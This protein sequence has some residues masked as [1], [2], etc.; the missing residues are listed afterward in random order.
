MEVIRIHVPLNFNSLNVIVG[1]SAFFFFLENELVE[2]V[3]RRPEDEPPVATKDGEPGPVS[4]FGARPVG[5]VRGILPGDE[6]YQLQFHQFNKRMLSAC[7]I[8]IYSIRSKI[9]ALIG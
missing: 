2:R 6:Q 5:E 7:L 9:Y 3:A 4:I 1:F 8:L